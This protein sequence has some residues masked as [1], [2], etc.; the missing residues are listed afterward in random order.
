MQCM[1]QTQ[2]VLHKTH[3]GRTHH[4]LRKYYSRRES[5]LADVLDGDNDLEQLAADEEE[6]DTADED[7]E[8]LKDVCFHLLDQEEAMIKQSA[9]QGNVP[10]QEA[11]GVILMP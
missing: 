1:R 11:R 10:Q 5:H 8:T 4:A 7:V 9:P 6:T 2:M 3:S